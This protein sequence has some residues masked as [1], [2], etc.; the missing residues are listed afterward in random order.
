MGL[1]SK[2]VAEFERPHE[3]RPLGS[4]W[5][6]GTLSILA[7]LAGLALVIVHYFPETF[8]MPELAV[9]HESGAVTTALRL[10]L[11]LGYV[12]SILSVILC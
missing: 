9:V 12:L 10:V 7:G 11:L 8:T 4:G 6:S 2:L 1:I 3:K 5:L